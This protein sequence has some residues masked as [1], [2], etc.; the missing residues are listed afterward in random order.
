MASKQGPTATYNKPAL[1]PADH[2]QKLKDQGLIVSD[3]TEAQKY[4]TFVGHYRL[5]GYWFQLQHAGTKA[6]LAN[7]SFDDIRNRYE[8]DREIRALILESVERLEVAIRSTICN[9]LSLKYSPHWHLKFDIFSHNPKSDFTIGKM[10]SKIESEVARSNNKVFISS[11]LGKY[12]EPYLPPSWAVGECLTMG[13]WSKIYSILK[14]TPDK[15]AIAAKFG[16]PEVD[17]FESWLHA[18][19]VLRNMAAHHDR[20]IANTLRVAPKNHV[21]KNIIFSNN[22]SVFAA[23]TMI[24]V[25]LE[26]TGFNGTFK[27]RIEGLEM[28]Y[29]TGM[30]QI[31]GFPQNWKTTPGWI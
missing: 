3:D 15:R 22:R 24:H 29:G 25:L 7:A 30:F 27:Q 28:K 31:L 6:F 17:V 26:A 11:Y 21:N 13:I 14:E 8:C 20:F 2:L 4:L 16:I 23:L 18:L 19:T 9:F 1:S 10:L 12:K 5:K